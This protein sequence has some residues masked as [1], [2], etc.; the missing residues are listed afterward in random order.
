MSHDV[1]ETAPL[2]DTI[3]PLSVISHE[4]LK[5]NGS[6]INR[7][8]DTNVTDSKLR[9]IQS[10]K[11]LASVLYHQASFD[12]SNQDVIIPNYCVLIIQTLGVILM[13]IVL[14]GIDIVGLIITYHP[15]WIDEMDIPDEC[16]YGDP[17]FHDFVIWFQ[18]ACWTMIG[19][20]FSSVITYAFGAPLL[21]IILNKLIYLTNSKCFECFLRGLNTFVVYLVLIVLPLFMIIWICI[22]IVEYATWDN[23]CRKIGMAIFIVVWLII[24]FIH[25]FVVAFYDIKCLCES[26]MKEQKKMKTGDRM[27]ICVGLCCLLK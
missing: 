18:I 15:T 21:T 2:N 27:E 1:K 3:Q 24:R 12:A 4:S 8:N 26:I 23:E 5:N 17:V 19:L 20:T 11:S 16:R 10:S 9:S 13:S 6:T 25:V 7:L 22:G 14:C